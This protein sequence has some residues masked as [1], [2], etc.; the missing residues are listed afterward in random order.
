MPQI[1]YIRRTAFTSPNN[2]G[3]AKNKLLLFGT[4]CHKSLFL[5]EENKGMKEDT[6]YKDIQGA[7]GNLPDNFNILEEQ[8]DIKVQM[9]Y[10]EFS[11]KIREDERF[12]GLVEDKKGLFLEETPT[13]RKKEILSALASVDDVKAYRT[14]EKFLENTKGILKPWAVLAL[15]E[16]RMLLQSSLLDE[17]QVFISSGLGGKGQKLRYFVVFINQNEEEALN[18][19]QRKLLK[20]E[21]I[22]ELKKHEGEFELIDFLEGFSTSQVMLPLS[23]NLKSIF[24]NIVDECNQYGGFLQED[25]IVTNVKVLS[26][27]EIIKML[28]NNV[29][30]ETESLEI[31]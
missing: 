20:E 15:Q 6:F 29:T 19:T 4:Y 21:L 11:Q 7:L 31:E 9:E 3:L 24:R 1:A 18:G 22:Y 5:S 16:N 10:F 13:E 2:L 30:D 23:A 14:I 28:N 26:R 12:A 27:D 17:Q 8:I 25:M